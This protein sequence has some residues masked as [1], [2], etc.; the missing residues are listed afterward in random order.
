MLRGS[1]LGGQQHVGRSINLD[2]Q[3]SGCLYYQATVGSGEDA[4]Q[5]CAD[6]AGVLP[7]SGLPQPLLKGLAAA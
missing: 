4:P 5:D 1:K 2:V 3:E 6:S 7:K